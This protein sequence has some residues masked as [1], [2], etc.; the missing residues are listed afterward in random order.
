MN[1]RPRQGRV[2]T[3]ALRSSYC[4]KDSINGLGIAEAFIVAEIQRVIPSSTPM[5]DLP[6][7]ASFETVESIKWMVSS[8]TEG[9]IL[10]LSFSLSDG[11]FSQVHPVKLYSPRR[12]VEKF[13]DLLCG[14][15]L[16]D[17]VSHSEFHRCNTQTDIGE[18]SLKTRGEVF[19]IRPQDVHK[20]VLSFIQS[21]GLQFFQI[22]KDPF[23][24]VSCHT[25]L[26]L[27]P[28]F[29]PF[30]EKNPEGGVD[31]LELLIH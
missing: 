7:E 6:A 28:V 21:P 20:L 9:R 19:Q 2:S 8:S 10:G 16:A 25:L 5:N 24:D 29:L 3:Q 12:A 23:F 27:R 30:T 26:K 1:A 22:G 14:S 17:Q 13:G 4:A 31:L 15:F 11:V 18:S